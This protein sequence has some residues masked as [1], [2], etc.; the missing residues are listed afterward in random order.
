M[1]TY[2]VSF[3]YAGQGPLQCSYDYLLIHLNNSL[4]GDNATFGLGS[5]KV[6][7]MVHQNLEPS[8]ALDGVE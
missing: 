8:A 5:T 3:V 7:R 2:I 1:H 6:D 4:K